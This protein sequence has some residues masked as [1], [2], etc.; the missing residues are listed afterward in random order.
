MLRLGCLFPCFP[1]FR[2]RDEF[3]LLYGVT[4]CISWSDS[5]EV[6]T[7]LTLDTEDIYSCLYGLLC[8][9][10]RIYPWLYGLVCFVQINAS[11][12]VN[13]HLTQCIDCPPGQNKET[14]VKRWPLVNSVRL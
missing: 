1:P 9:V 13:L 11:L 7:F 8:L 2:S 10:R 14:V 3:L 12:Q 6:T 4:R 5:H